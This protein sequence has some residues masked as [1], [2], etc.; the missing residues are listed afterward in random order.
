VFDALL[1][2]VGV[3]MPILF[4]AVVVGIFWT[5]F[6]QYEADRAELRAFIEHAFDLTS[7]S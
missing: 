6:Q 7:S 3:G 1:L 2:L 4:A 5:S